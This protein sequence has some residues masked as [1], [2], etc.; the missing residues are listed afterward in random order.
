MATNELIVVGVDGSRDGRQ[1]LRWAVSEAQR[2]GGA[3]EAVTAWYWHGLDGPALAVSDAGT[4]RETAERISADEVEAVSAE[5]G[6]GIPIAR[7]VVE[8]VPVRVLVEASKKA[9]LL[10]VGSHGHSRLQHTLLGSVSHECVRQAACPVVV[11]PALRA[12]AVRVPVDPVPAT[13]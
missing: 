5:F 8:G 1:A 13:R 9:R 7:E 11:I 2:S 6:S 12:E 4:Q 10:V 3:V